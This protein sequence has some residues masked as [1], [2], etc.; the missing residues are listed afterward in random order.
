[1]FINDFDNNGTIDQILTRALDGKDKP[2]HVRNEL[3]S[4]IAK[5]KKENVQF[6]AYA[7]KGVRDLFSK[8][9][10]AGA[11][12]KEV[13]ESKSILV[14]NKG[15]LFFEQKPL[16]REIQWN[17]VNTGVVSDFNQDGHVDVLLAGGEDNLKPQFGK[18]DAGYGELLIGDGKGNFQWQPYSQ[19]GLKV[20]GTVR[21]SSTIGWNGKNAVIFGINDEKALIY[22]SKK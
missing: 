5:V 12:I 21:S 7:T 3:V 13:N 22:V 1:M 4:Q 19:S 16:P 17:S 11:L 18:L 10:I 9:N 14:L 20:R 2:I 8:E 15:N 6:S